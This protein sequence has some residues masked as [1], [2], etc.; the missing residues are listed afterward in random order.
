MAGIFL[1]AG[2]G[3]LQM[4]RQPFENEGVL[5]QVIAEHPEMLSNEDRLERLLLVRREAPVQQEHDSTLSLDHLYLDSRGILTLVEVKQGASSE[6]RRKV[7][8]Q[9]LDYAANAR[10]SF[11]PDRLSEWLEVRAA[12]QQTTVQALLADTLGVADV[13]AYWAEVASNLEAEQ[14]R[15]V[16]VSDEIPRSLRRIIEF[17]NAQMIRTEVLAIEVKQYA[18]GEGVHQTIV[19]RVIGDSEAARQTKRTGG[20]GKPIDR[21]TLL[22]ALAEEDPGAAAAAGAL[23][24]WCETEPALDLRWRRETADF[25]RPDRQPLIRIWRDGRLEVRLQTLRAKDVGW[26]LERCK[27]LMDELEAIDGLSFDAGRSWPKAEISAL[28]GDDSRDQFLAVMAAVVA[29]IT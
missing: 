24:D 29:E 22:S 27:A 17:L 15:L 12:E 7:V 23:I 14:L 3:Y 18:D 10:R 20:G 21:D 28:S 11:G 4:D 13:D 26:D 25:G 5:Q 6:G 16:F 9:M 1:R 2:D 19:P 8:A